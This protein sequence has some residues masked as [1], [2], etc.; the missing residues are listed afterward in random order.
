MALVENPAMT[1]TPAV[2]AS[3][4]LALEP[5]DLP[6]DAQEPDRITVAV[7]DGE[8]FMALRFRPGL[9]P[10]PFRGA[11]SGQRITEEQ[12]LERLRGDPEYTPEEILA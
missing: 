2:P 11:L 7:F 8:A 6:D 3:C 10:M 1:S 5:V 12:V 4:Y 9:P